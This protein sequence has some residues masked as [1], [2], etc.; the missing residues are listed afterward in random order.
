[1]EKKLTGVK[2]ERLTNGFVVEES[3]Y[4]KREKEDEWEDEETYCDSIE[5]AVEKVKEVLD[6]WFAEEVN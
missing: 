3:W 5:S 2:V 4:E 1:M 6:K